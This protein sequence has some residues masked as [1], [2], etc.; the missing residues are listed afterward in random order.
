LNI[1]NGFVS[2]Y[3]NIIMKT[4]R[5]ISLQ[6]S[7]KSKYMVYVLLISL[8][9]CFTGITA[10]SQNHM[11]TGVELIVN[12]DFENDTVGITSDYHYSKSNLKPEGTWSVLKN[13]YEV[14]YLFSN[15][16]DH[17]TGS[18]SMMCVNGHYRPDQ[19]VW[20]QIIND[21]Q[22][23]TTYFFSMWLTPVNPD[24]PS[25]LSIYFNNIEVSGSPI[26]LSSDTCVWQSFHCDWSS[27]NS[28]SATIKIVNNNLAEIG[29]DFALDDISLMPYCTVNADAG[30]DV[31]ICYGE[32]ITI[33]REATGGSPPYNYEWQQHPGIIATDQYRAT[34]SNDETSQYV[35]KV[36]DEIGCIDYDTVTVTVVPEIFFEISSSVELP[37]CPCETVV[38]SGP[39][40][41]NYL[42][43]TGETTKD[44]IVTNSGEYTLKVETDEGCFA[45]DHLYVEISTAEF[46]VEVNYAEA[47][48]GETI[49]IPIDIYKSI[50]NPRCQFEDLN[51]RLTYN[52]SLLHPVLPESFV[53]YTQDD[54]QIIEYSGSINELERSL[55]FIATLGNSRCTDIVIDKFDLGCNEIR[56]NLT[57][58]RFCSSNICLDPT[59][60]LFD[61]TGEFFLA[62][63]IPNPA[64]ETTSI[65]F[66]LIETGQTYI[67]LINLLGE[68]IDILSDSI[69]EPGIYN[70]DY[71][72]SNLSPG[73]YFII[74]ET[75][76]QMLT[77]RLDII[78]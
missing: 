52:K 63:N 75:P 24:R 21:I 62:Q 61:D 36:T 3:I 8:F 17:T 51:L 5:N 6:K 33:G 68:K 23:N 35:V 46:F 15:C 34:I 22:P 32:T 59:P 76:S 27:G 72:V 16:T 2:L 69:L 60:R 25:Y 31:S 47:K 50:S 12:G 4:E 1:Q 64:S 71:D 44:I 78:K 20:Q 53:Q 14:F 57:H 30:N 39:E 19:V 73:V 10:Y 42:W 11:L 38:L 66:G 70:I 29:N 56:M 45:T 77:K 43:S 7:Q 48:S 18:G 67:S 9:I 37:S 41:Y 55:K 13:P 28:N 54:L 40:G 74:L 65:Q 58:G 26:Y 49:D